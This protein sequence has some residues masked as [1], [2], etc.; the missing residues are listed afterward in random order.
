MP[1]FED[2]RPVL[3]EGFVYQPDVIDVEAE[4]AVLAHVRLLEFG[5]VVMRGH[6]AAAC[7]AVRLALLLRH[8]CRQ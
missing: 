5:N 8:S 2:L 3:P 1:L 6:G 4:Q 7:R